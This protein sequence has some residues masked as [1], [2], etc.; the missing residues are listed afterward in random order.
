MQ[1]KTIN[2]LIG[3]GILVFSIGFFLGLNWLKYLQLLMPIGSLMTFV[4]VFYFFKDTNLNDQFKKA[5]N[6]DVLTY[7]WNVIVLKFWTFVFVLWMIS[8]D[9]IL[10]FKGMI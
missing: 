5:D 7:F 9:L 1:I 6:E 8:M 10:I 3:Y 2:K 4:G